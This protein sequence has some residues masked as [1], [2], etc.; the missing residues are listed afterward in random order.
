MIFNQNQSDTP[1]LKR[2]EMSTSSLSTFES[3][4]S[5]INRVEVN[6]D[7]YALPNKGTIKVKVFRLT[8]E[9]NEEN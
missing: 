8:A 9:T 6:D 1:E 2:K 5:D 7:L 3:Q 4:D